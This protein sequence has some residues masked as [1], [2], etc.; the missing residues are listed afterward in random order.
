MKCSSKKDL[1]RQLLSYRRLL[2]QGTFQ[3][4]NASLLMR[5]KHVMDE[6]QHRRIH[7]FLPIRRNNEP[8]LQPLIDDIW[9]T[10]IPV[11]ISQTDFDSKKMSHFIFDQNTR[12]VENDLGIPEPIGAFP[13]NLEEVDL[14]FIPLLA[15]DR[16][17]N[18]I[19]YGGGYYDRLLSETN[20]QIKKIGLSLSSPLDFIPFAENHDIPLDMCITPNEILR[21]HD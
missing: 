13:T 7:T 12:L 15:A 20:D 5:I 4:R 21:Y 10:Q 17:G 9:Q 3:S 11:V 8:D 16:Q 18:R 14:I 2:D 19:G 6:H 1:R